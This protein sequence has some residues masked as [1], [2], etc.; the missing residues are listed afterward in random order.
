MKL[1]AVTHI[2]MFLVSSVCHIAP[3][4]TLTSR[5]AA[6]AEEHNTGSLSRVS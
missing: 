2:D 3:L 6:V 5:L 4:F 1:H